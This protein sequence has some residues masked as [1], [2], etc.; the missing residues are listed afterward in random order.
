MLESEGIIT[1]ESNVVFVLR[2]MVD[3]KAPRPARPNR[4]LRCCGTVNS[5]TLR[6][7]RHGMRRCTHGRAAAALYHAARTVA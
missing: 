4:L 2:F 3:L 6:V 7:V 5:R 1:Y